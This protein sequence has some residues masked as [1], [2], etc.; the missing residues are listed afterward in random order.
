MAFL[1]KKPMVSSSLPLYTLGNNKTVLIVGLGNVGKEYESTRHN[2]GFNVIDD[3]AERNEFPVWVEKKDFKCHMTYQNMGSTRV[4]LIKPTTYMNESGQAAAAAQ[5]FYK[6]ATP[7]TVAVYDELA[8]PYGQIRARVG[9]ETAGH[10]GV[11]SL[12]AHLGDDFGRLRIG[13]ANDISEK[14]DAADFVLGK[15][16]VEEKGQLPLIVKEA[17]VMLT[18]YI[19]SGQLPHETRK[20]L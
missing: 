14:A 19:F 4:I 15:F 11:K 18:E 9:G 16:T 20:I 3:F 5:H 10:N 6:I 2:L 7:D 8:L 13:I 1:Q 12:T 17:G